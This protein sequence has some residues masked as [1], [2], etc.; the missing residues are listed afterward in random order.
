[1][2]FMSDFAEFFD[3]ELASPSLIIKE[4]GFSMGREFMK[5]TRGAGPL[6]AVMG[7]VPEAMGA[8]SSYSGLRSLAKEKAGPLIDEA[9]NAISAEQHATML[10]KK[11][12]EL[13]G[14]V[15]KSVLGTVGGLASWAIPEIKGLG[16]IGSIG[17]QMAATMG[18]GFVGKEIG[19]ALG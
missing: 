8:V 1:M 18:S 4:A 13:S 6:L 16:L 7:E 14:Q 11:K 3:A 10:K 2:G 12:K 15:G 5:Q 9:G 17:T 19:Q